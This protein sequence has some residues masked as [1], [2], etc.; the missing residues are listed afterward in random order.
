MAGAG[1]M[2]VFGEKT[3][4]GMDHV[5]PAIEGQPDNALNVEISPDRAFAA[6]H[7][8]SLVGLESVDGEAVFLRVD[9][10]GPHM[11]LVGGPEN[12]DGD[13]AAVGHEQGLPGD[14]EKGVIGGWGYFC[15]DRIGGFPPRAE[16]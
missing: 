7:D 3:V 4:A 6:A 16:T 14:V 9:R 2:G 13:L 1:E 15:H 8:V 12:T 10:N 5:H 11:E